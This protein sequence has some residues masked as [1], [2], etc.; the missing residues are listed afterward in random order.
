[1][2]TSEQL[3][4]MFPNMQQSLAD[5]FAPHLAPAMQEFGIDTALRKS[6]FLANA[7]YETDHLRYTV[8]RLNFTTEELLKNYP[9][10]FVD[11]TLSKI[12]K[13]KA[14]QI[15]NRIY[16]RRWGNA[17]EPKDDGWNYRGRGLLF[18][19]GR[20][21]YLELGKTLSLDLVKQP[22]L[23]ETEQ[24]SVR[25]AAWLWNKHTL[26]T[27]ADRNDV[28]AL[29]KAIGSDENLVMRKLYQVA[30]LDVLQQIS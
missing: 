24:G 18:V 25:A 9:N 4:R 14:R 10:H 8:E 6:W 7:I 17:G 13:G 23:L 15:A 30:A 16:G 28:L 26:N 11:N 2:I 12:Y 19:R 21:R 27:H 20:D 29:T 1:M 22:Q 5:R 3:L